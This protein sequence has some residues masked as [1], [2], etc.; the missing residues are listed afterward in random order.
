M[1]RRERSIVSPA[2]NEPIDK[3]ARPAS[4]APRWRSL[5]SAVYRDSFMTLSIAVE[6]T[7]GQTGLHYSQ[8]S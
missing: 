2:R 8:F 5:R 1:R 4:T 7:A 6:T 3:G